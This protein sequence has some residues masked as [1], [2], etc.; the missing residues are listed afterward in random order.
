MINVCIY[1]GEN[2]SKALEECPFCLRSPNS[3]EDEI[4]SIILCFSETEPYLNFLSRE[5]IEAIR[6]NII[7]G[8]PIELKAD[9]LNRAEEAFSAVKSNN[10]PKLIQSFSTISFPIIAII[11]LTMLATLFL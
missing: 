11:V 3:H 9:I 7:E 5:E 2:K 1:C 10:G 4:R 6:I 8:S